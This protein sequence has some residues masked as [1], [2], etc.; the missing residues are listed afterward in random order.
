V[1]YLAAA[2]ASRI[3]KKKVPLAWHGMKYFPLKKDLK[4]TLTRND[5]KIY[6]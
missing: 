1:L 2:S 6:G 4:Q 5:E 3:D